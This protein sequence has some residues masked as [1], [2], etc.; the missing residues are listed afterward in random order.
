MLR[1]RQILAVRRGGVVGVPAQ[2]FTEDTHHEGEV[3]VLKQLPGLIAVLHDGGYS[4]EESL[5]WMYREDPSLPGRPVDA[6]HGHLA[7]EV[8]RRAQA[9]AF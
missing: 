8:L 3:R 9:M 6:L 7:R 4:P 2:F 1:D 5:R